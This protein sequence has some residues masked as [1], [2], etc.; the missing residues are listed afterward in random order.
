MKEKK[1]MSYLTNFLIIIFL[2]A[3]TETKAREDGVIRITCVGDS[4]T[5]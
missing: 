4:I 3:I 2:M 1:F 5:D